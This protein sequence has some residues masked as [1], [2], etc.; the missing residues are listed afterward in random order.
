[1]VGNDLDTAIDAWILCP[2][3]G[4]RPPVFRSKVDALAESD[5]PSCLLTLDSTRSRRGSWNSAG[6]ALANGLSWH[7]FIIGLAHGTLNEP[8]ISRDE[9]TVSPRD[10]IVHSGVAVDGWFAGQRSLR[11]VLKPRRDTPARGCNL[12]VD[13]A[14]H[15]DAASIARG[16]EGFLVS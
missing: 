11:R 13:H 1:M 3:S 2:I 5:L 6:V 16:V 10:E 12:P 9:G 7:E 8:Q 14:R 15:E 4:N